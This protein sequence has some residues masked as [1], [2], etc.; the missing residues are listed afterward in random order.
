MF[1]GNWKQ[2]RKI[3]LVMGLTFLIG[4]WDG[5]GTVPI[6]DLKAA[7]ANQ[8]D[9]NSNAVKHHGAEHQAGNEEHHAGKHGYHK[10]F[11]GIDYWVKVFNDPKRDKWQ[12]PEKVVSALKEVAPKFQAS[13]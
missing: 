4:A 2:H 7:L 11:K 1:T 8:V 9:H 3:A 10:E 13:G 5:V 6:E 12:R